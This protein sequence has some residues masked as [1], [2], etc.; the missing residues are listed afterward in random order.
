M[1]TTR[2]IVN[3][4]A[5]LTGFFG[6]AWA[7]VGPAAYIGVL[8][9]FWPSRWPERPADAQLLAIVTLL[10]VVLAILGGSALRSLRTPVRTKPSFS[11]KLTERTKIDLSYLR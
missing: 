4:L 3:G 8:A 11:Q 5:L 2:Y 6:L 9:G 10:T 7:L 1:H